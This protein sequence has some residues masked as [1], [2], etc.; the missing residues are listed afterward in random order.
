M[1]VLVQEMICPSLS[2]AQWYLT[3]PTVKQML[4]LHPLIIHGYLSMYIPIYILMYILM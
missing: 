1:T 2:S 3:L 4:L